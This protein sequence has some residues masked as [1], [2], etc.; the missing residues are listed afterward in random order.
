MRRCVYF[1]SD[2]HLGLDV[3]DPGAREERLARFLESVPAEETEAL[4]LLGDVWDFWYEYRDVVPAGYARV[5]AALQSLI[6]RGVEVHFFSGNHDIWCYRYFQSLGIKVHHGPELVSHSGKSF[7]LAHGDG[8][9][10]GMH[11]Y[12]CMKAVFRSRITQWLF[13]TFVPVRLAFAL[14]KGW[15]RHNRLA[16]GERYVFK[17]ESEPL[18]KWS[19]AIDPQPDYFVF[20]HLH[21]KVNMK[22]PSGAGLF[23]LGDWLDG[24]DVLCFDGESLSRL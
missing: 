18:Y 8:L 13:S 5:F 20:G 22:M 11:V 19:A 23:V 12:K 6:S 9:G 2:V 16:R 15:S 1:L 10:P 4:Y 14:G 24:S 21:C 17:G 3:C 7:M